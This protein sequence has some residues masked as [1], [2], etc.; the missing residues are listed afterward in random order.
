[1][2]KL[3]QGFIH[4]IKHPLFTGGFILTISN[5]VASASNYFFHLIT[6]RLLGPLQY[7]TLASLISLS[8][9]IGVVSAVFSTSIMRQAAKFWAK[10]EK[11][12]T[13]WFYREIFYQV[14]IFSFVFLVFYLLSSSLIADFL[15]INDKFLVWQMGIAGF[16]GLITITNFA[17]LQALLKFLYFGLLNFAGGVLKIVFI[18]GLAFFGLNVTRS[19]WVL[20]ISGAIVFVCSFLPLLRFD[21]KIF[22]LKEKFNFSFL[23]FWTNSI[24]VFLAVLGMTSLY[25]TDLILVKHFLTDQQ[26]GLYSS[27]SVLGKIIFF[28]S[29]PIL[30]AMM[31]LIIKKKEWGENF[32]KPF[33]FTLTFVFLCCLGFTLIYYLFPKLI[34]WL[35]YGEKFLAASFLLGDFAVFISFYSLTNVFINFYI[36]IEDNRIGF[37]PIIAALIQIMCLSFFHHDL[38]QVIFISIMTLAGLLISLLIYFNYGKEKT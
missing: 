38:R 25:T 4:L 17:F 1:M 32:K 36:A 28:A 27:L 29:S 3:R 12:K 5:L 21:G 11:K 24:P 31:P 33:F 6:G 26:T 14:F 9:F 23:H 18:L 34:L 2:N 22:K 37:F 8:Y 10:E 20:I 30:I 7:S 35:L 19:L 15:K 13:I 16:L